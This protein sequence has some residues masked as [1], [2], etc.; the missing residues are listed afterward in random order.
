MSVL[1]INFAPG[2]IDL[3]SDTLCYADG[4]PHSLCE[5][6]THIPSSGQFS[7]TTRGLVRTGERFDELAGKCADADAASL[8]ARV[9]AEMLTDDEVANG[10]EITVAGWSD[11]LGT[12]A[13]QMVTKAPGEPV[14]A[15]TFTE[16]VH[17][18]PR[19][20]KLP[21]MPSTVSEAQFIRLA[22]AQWKV[23]DQFMGQLCIGG[24]MH[25]TTVTAAG[26]DQRIVGL[27]PD[28]DQHAEAFGD[29]NAEAVA[30][31]LAQQAAA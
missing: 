12:L 19:P 4:E 7:W 20:A 6:K 1:N 30:A 17:L 8:A 10:F 5:T 14:K 23:R 28:Y 31:F 16:G 25:L 2:R 3:L 18:L 21:P 24:V 26:A 15:E 11:R 29:P 27:Y 13:M 9:F 22:L